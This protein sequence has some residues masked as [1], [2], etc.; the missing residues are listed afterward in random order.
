MASCKLLN[1]PQDVFKL[2]IQEQ[3][4]IK[5]ARGTRQFSFESTI[6]KMLRDYDKCRK[7]NNFK[8][9]EV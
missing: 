8:P 5:E 4:K 6:Y 3:S 7:S 1:I 9:D 2:V